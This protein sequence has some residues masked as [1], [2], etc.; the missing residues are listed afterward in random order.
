MKKHN[1]LLVVRHPVGGIR[2]FFR[3]VYTNFDPEKYRF[4]LLAPEWPE[5][6][7]LLDDLRRLDLEYIPTDH[8]VSGIKLFRQAT[9]ILMTRHF[10]L[11]HS[12]GFTAGVSLVPSAFL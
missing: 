8:D 5:T 3:Y 12:H 11:V 7:L 2:T 6:V 9:R 4:T 10:D 1:I